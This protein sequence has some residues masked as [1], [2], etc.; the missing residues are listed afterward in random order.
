MFK[1]AT[2]QEA[3]KYFMPVKP[4]FGMNRFYPTI[5]WIIKNQALDNIPSMFLK[6]FELD[7]APSPRD[8]EV[9]LVCNIC[10]AEFIGWANNG[11]PK[12]SGGIL[13]NEGKAFRCTCP[14]GDQHFV[15]NSLASA[16]LLKPQ[17]YIG[18]GEI[19]AL[20]SNTVNKHMAG[21]EELM[22]VELRKRPNAIV[23]E[24]RVSDNSE[25]FIPAKI[26]GHMGDD[27]DLGPML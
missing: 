25:D 13:Y 24:I 12:Y 6:T 14:A 7:S 17:D 15:T 20:D 8:E 11:A 21:V 26:P 9:F 3:V 18:K 16:K 27:Q 19:Y 5:G 4:K 1:T 2:G 22:K 23:R 10:E